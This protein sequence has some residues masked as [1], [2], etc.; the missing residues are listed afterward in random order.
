MY[1]IIIRY[2]LYLY[3]VLSGTLPQYTGV[4][5]RSETSLVVAELISDLCVPYFCTMYFIV[6]HIR[7]LF[8]FFNAKVV[9][10]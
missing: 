1:I 9:Y 8:Y 6:L 10:T 5:T 7:E 2:I 3:N 4:Y